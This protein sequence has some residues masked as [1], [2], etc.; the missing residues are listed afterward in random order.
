MENK[1]ERVQMSFH[2]HILSLLLIN[3]VACSDSERRVLVIEQGQHFIRMQ[4]RKL[5]IEQEQD[6]GLNSCAYLLEAK[7]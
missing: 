6:L 4:K 1:G 3:L 7:G 2:T 5:C